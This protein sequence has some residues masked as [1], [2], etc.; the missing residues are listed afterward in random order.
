MPNTPAVAQGHIAD[1]ALHTLGWKAFQDLCAQICAEV[2]GCTVSVYR[3]AQDG[4]QDA[5]FLLPKG[6]QSQE[7]SVQCKFCSKQDQR[8]KLSDLTGELSNVESL[9][10]EKRAYAYYFITS[11]RV[12]APIAAQI[13]DRLLALGVKEPHVLGREW[14]TEQ[15]KINPR[16]RAL[17]PRVYGLGDLSTILDERSAAQTRRLLGHLAPSLRVYVEHDQLP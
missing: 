14:I 7:S 6:Q 16:L 9:V 11:M 13:R 1:F 4:G 12:D 10:V 17:V 5:V 3:E 8:L 2:L 15:I